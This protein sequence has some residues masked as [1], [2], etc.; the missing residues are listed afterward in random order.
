M[1][2]DAIFVNEHEFRV[3]LVLTARGGWTMD[4]LHVDHTGRAIAELRTS[5]DI[6]FASEAE[7]LRYAKIVA[8]DMAQ[9]R[10]GGGALPA[11]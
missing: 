3:T 10:G 5:I 7:A 6:E 8:T 2:G 11:H 4:I 1:N 9:R